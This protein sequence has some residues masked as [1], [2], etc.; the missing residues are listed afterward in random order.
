MIVLRV[1]KREIDFCVN[2][3]GVHIIILEGLTCVES[4]ESLLEMWRFK[5]LSLVVETERTR[6]DS[7]QSGVKMND[8]E[9]AITLIKHDGNGV[10]VFELKKNWK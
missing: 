1:I 4:G 8:C 3:E 7:S 9:M 6:N 2:I 5:Q 10:C